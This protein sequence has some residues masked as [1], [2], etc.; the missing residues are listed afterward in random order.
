MP[1]ERMLRKKYF[2]A[3]SALFVFPQRAREIRFDE[4]RRDAVHAD[5]VRREIDG[6]TLDQM[7]DRAGHGGRDR[8]SLLRAVRGHAVGQHDR[9]AQGAG[10]GD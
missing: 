9:A 3:L 1:D 10:S 5:V 7:L 4:S 8:Q 2:A 6:E